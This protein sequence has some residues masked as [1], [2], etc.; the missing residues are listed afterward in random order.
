MW[1]MRPGRPFENESALEPIRTGNFHLPLVIR[2]R[3]NDEDPPISRPIRKHVLDDRNH[4]RP[5]N[6]I[7]GMMHFHDHCHVTRENITDAREAAM[8][9]ADLVQDSYFRTIPR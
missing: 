3:A 2:L 4:I 6:R 1:L 7:A 5:K 9:R 8:A